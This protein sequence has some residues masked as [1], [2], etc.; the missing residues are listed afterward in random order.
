MLISSWYQAKVFRRFSKMS[1]VFKF[2]SESS[3][4]ISCIRFADE[5]G[6]PVRFIYKRTY[7][8]FVKTPPRFQNS[9]LFGVRG[10]GGGLTTCGPRNPPPCLTGPPPSARIFPQPLGAASIAQKPRRPDSRILR[11]GEASKTGR[12]P[13]R[14]PPIWTTFGSEASR[15]HQGPQTTP[16]RP[17]KSPPPGRGHSHHLAVPGTGAGAPVSYTHL[18]LPT[19]R[20]V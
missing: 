1:G 4:P 15:S 12:F 9:P 3:S 2:S 13:L 11:S 10:Q 5:V 6:H 16:P 17:P 14:K 8:C 7:G 20:E 19:N 18:T